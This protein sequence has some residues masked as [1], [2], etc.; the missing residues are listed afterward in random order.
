MTRLAIVT[1]TIRVPEVLADYVRGARTAG[2]DFRLYIVGDRK[3]PDL[4]DYAQRLGPEVRWISAASHGR[5]RTSAVLRWDCIMRRN[6]GFLEAAADGPFEFYLSLDDDNLPDPGYFETFASL[7]TRRHGHAV[8]ATQGWFNYFRDADTD[9]PVTPHARGFPIRRRSQAEWSTRRCD[10]PAAD[11]WA[12]QGLSRGDPD[13]DAFTHIATHVRIR[14]FAHQSLIARH[15]WSPINSQNTFLREPLLPLYLMFDQIGRFDD[16]VAG[17][18]LQHYVYANGGW[19]HFGQPF[20]RQ[21]R[22]VRDWLRDFENEVEG[23]LTIERLL[24]HLQGKPVSGIS[25][26]EAMRRIS[27]PSPQ[28]PAFFERHRPLVDAWLA[29]LERVG[30]G[31]WTVPMPESPA[32]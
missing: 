12:F 20:T 2:F 11:V 10:V 18:L 8:D 24:A 21:E 14:R 3:T 19:V 22:G 25:A 15:A 16:I 30:A 5:W 28:G 17:Y 23:H 9:P 31:R 27:A 29:D 4:R 32:A 6:I 7:L 26:P 1:T 13:V